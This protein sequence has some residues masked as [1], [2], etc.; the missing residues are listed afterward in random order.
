[1]SLARQAV[2]AGYVGDRAGALAVWSSGSASQRALALSALARMGAFG[3]KE[4]LAAC[5]HHFAEVRARALELAS[6]LTPPAWSKLMEGMA[7][8]DWRVV[9]AACFCAGESADNADPETRAMLARALS[10][11]A[12]E[13]EDPLCA[14]AAVAALGA[15]GHPEGLDALLR[16]VSGPPAIRRRAVVALAAFE[17]PEV[18]GAL[19]KALVD[20]DWQVRQVA[21]DLL[22]RPGPSRT[23]S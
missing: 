11:V 21:E 16:A 1:M 19:E 20:R 5:D 23:T 9:E 8:P 14:E 7:D 6:Q 4:L 12:R 3:S 18:Q 2:V 17:G 15:I 13:H 10:Q 22:G